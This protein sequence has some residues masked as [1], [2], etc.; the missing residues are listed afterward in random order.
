MVI[1]KSG[2]TSDVDV[3]MNLDHGKPAYK[4]VQY[5]NGESVNVVIDLNIVDAACFLHDLR[6]DKVKVPAN[7]VLDIM[8]AALGSKNEA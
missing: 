2:P 7:F 4:I 6:S 5:K 1:L 8:R 3:L